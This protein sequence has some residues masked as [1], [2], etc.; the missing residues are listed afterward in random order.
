MKYSIQNYPSGFYVYAYL[1]RDG[2]PYYIGKGKKNRAWKHHAKIAVP[3][4]DCRI[5]IC[6]S[7]LTEIGALSIERRLI[8]WYGRKDLGTGILRNM[9]DGGEGVIGMKKSQAACLAQS[10]RL[11]GVPKSADHKKKIRDS[12]LGKQRSDHF[13]KKRTE[14]NIQRAIIY[15]WHN[16]LTNETV[17]MSRVDFRE[18]TGF[19][20][21]TVQRLITEGKDSRGWKVIKSD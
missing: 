4:D 18:K 12:N 9:T 10:R 19:G 2:T 8:G 6:E 14:L 17:T 16:T 13:R 5:V 3:K 15:K 20:G 1:R 21:G 11:K 7:N